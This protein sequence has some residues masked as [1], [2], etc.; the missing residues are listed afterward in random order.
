MIRKLYL[1]FLMIPLLSLHAA[2]E[3]RDTGARSSAMAG[4]V[5]A[6][7]DDLQSMMINPAGLAYLKGFGFKAA[8][9]RY[10]PSLDG[11][12][13]I[14][15]ID[16]SAGIPVEF[17]GNIALSWSRFGSENYGEQ[18]FG[19]HHGFSLF[20]TIALG[21]S[22]NFLS[23]KTGSES[24]V[25]GF[26]IDLGGTAKYSDKF[27][28]GFAGKNLLGSVLDGSSDNLSREGSVGVCYSPAP[29]LL[30][31]L[32]AVKR[33]GSG[34]FLRTGQEIRLSRTLSMRT[35]AQTGT[36]RFT[37]GFGLAYRWFDLDYAFIYQNETGPQSL[38]T[39]AFDAS[40]AV[41]T[42]FHEVKPQT[43]QEITLEDL[44]PER[45]YMGEKIN[46]NTAGIEELTALPRVGPSLAQGIIDYREK[47]G[48]FLHK[49]DLI[50]VSRIGVKTYAQ[51]R[52]FITT[53]YAEDGSNK[54]VENT[55][56]EKADINSIS[57]KELINRG[58]PAMMAVKITRYRDEQ[59]LIY[60][61]EQ[62]KSIPGISAE[63]LERAEGIILP[64]LRDNNE[65]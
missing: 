13:T 9:I 60:S 8:G 28:F 38:F 51:F 12:E 24:P 45:E 56:E 50:K 33:M 64:L 36:M 2:F 20:H 17:A 16:F 52:S 62:I 53:G 57:L 25:R 40:E 21:S 15:S 59:E 55:S 32:D 34:F 63:D 3:S 6:C 23:L 48:P 49:E 22:F 44:G 7:A 14:T 27:R 61:W 31:S 46:I 35:G 54:P 1:F 37:A 42:V 4:A 29:G 39:L 30:I 47:N 65:E 5:T 18:I 11:L 19:L 10:F 26:S 43:K 58:V 41:R